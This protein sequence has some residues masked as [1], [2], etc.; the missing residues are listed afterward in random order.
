MPSNLDL[1]VPTTGLVVVVVVVVVDI[2]NLSALSNLFNSSFFLSSAEPFVKTPESSSFD[3]FVVVGSLEEEEVGVA[4]PTFL[5]ET[6]EDDLERIPPPPPP[7]P[8][9]EVLLLLFKLVEA[10][11][12]EEGLL[13]KLEFNEILKGGPA[14]AGVVVG[15]GEFVKVVRG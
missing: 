2:P 6:I 10:E 15:R 9:C 5:S 7:V 8:T 13:G 14:A 1:L 4:P 11:E 3:R 12:D